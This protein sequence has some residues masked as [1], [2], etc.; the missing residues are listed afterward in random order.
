MKKFDRMSHLVPDICWAEKDV[1]S[2]HR[3]DPVG[4]SEEL[5]ASAVL[6]NSLRHDTSRVYLTLQ[7]H[8]RVWLAIKTKMD[9]T[10]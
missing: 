9:I 8:T 7:G 10:V 1:S 6:Q 5:F 4:G 3:L 2:H